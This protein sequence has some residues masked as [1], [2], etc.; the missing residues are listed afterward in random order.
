MTI[1]QVPVLIVG[2]G[3]GG[4]TTSAVLARHGVSSLLVDKRG[5]VFVYPKG[6]HL[7]FLSLEIL[8]GLGLDDEVHAVA[9]GVSDMLVKPTLNSAEQNQALDF[10]AIFAGFDH[11]H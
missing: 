2:A 5:E 1:A 7:S 8:R 3:A 10:D 6:R 9:E 11:L 4:L